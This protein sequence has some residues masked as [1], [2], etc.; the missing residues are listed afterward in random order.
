MSKRDTYHNLVRAALEELGWDV[1]HDPLSVKAGT[2]KIRVDLGAELIGAEKGEEKI[3]VE[4]KSFLRRS[5]LTD[6]Y[7]ALGKFRYYKYVLNQ[8][9]PERILFLAIPEDFYV[10]FF[11]EEVFNQAI[12]EIENLKIILFNIEEGKIT[13]WIK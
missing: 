4:I 2:R 8:S 5:E 11:E 12:I 13:K 6:F 7:E 1:T 3:A 10:T 9:M